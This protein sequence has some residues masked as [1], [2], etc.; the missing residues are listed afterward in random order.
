MD[1]KKCPW[2]GSDLSGEICPA[3]FPAL[4]EETEGEREAAAFWIDVGGE[5]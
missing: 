1:E 3:C 5:G 2:C 4:R